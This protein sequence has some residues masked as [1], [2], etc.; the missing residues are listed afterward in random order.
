MGDFWQRVSVLSEGDCNRC[1]EHKGLAIPL[2]DDGLHGWCAPCAVLELGDRI[3][4]EHVDPEV[5]QDAY[6]AGE[7]SPPGTRRRSECR[8]APASPTGEAGDGQLSAVRQEVERMRALA[9][10]S[11]QPGR[12]TAFGSVLRAI[13]RIE[14]AAPGE[15]PAGL[16]EY[17]SWLAAMASREDDRCEQYE[18]AGLNDDRAARLSGAADAYQRALDKFDVL[19]EPGEA[20]E[21]ERADGLTGAEGEVMDHA[22]GVVRAYAA[23]P[24]QHPDDM[25][26]I[27]DAVHR[28]QDLLAVRIARRHYPAGWPIK[29]AAAEEQGNGAA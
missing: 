27:A 22:L 5:I 19:A 24:V 9:K 29:G 26:D 11:G 28:V 14:A 15:A 1:G 20:R 13:D 6:D 18:T 25:R 21:G 17:R 3:E 8:P 12:W 2:G 4:A 23:L 7:L 16:G 10:E